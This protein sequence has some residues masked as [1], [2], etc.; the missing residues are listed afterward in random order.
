[1]EGNE[2]PASNDTSEESSFHWPEEGSRISDQE[3]QDGQER[4]LTF[5]LPSCHCLEERIKQY[6]NAKFG[7]EVREK[8]QTEVLAPDHPALQ[9]FQKALKEHLQRQIERL[10]EEIYEFDT[11]IKNKN[12]QKEEMGVAVYELQQAVCKQQKILEEYIDNVKTATAAREELEI[13]VRECKQKFKAGA[14][15]LLMAQKEEKELRNEVESINLLVQQTANWEKEVESEIKISKRMTEKTRKDQLQLMEEKRKQD[16]I[17]YRLQTEV[18]RLETELETIDMK[19]EIKERERE[20]LAQTVAEGSTTIDA[21]EAEYRCLMHS[22]N[23]VVIAIG[24]RDKVL[25]CVSQEVQKYEEEYKNILCETEQIRKLA[26]QEM[27]G[28]E[29]LTAIKQRILS[30]IMTCKNQIDE[31]VAKQKKLEGRITKYQALIEQIELDIN[32][33]EIKNRAEETSLTVLCRECDKKNQMKCDWEEKIFLLLEDEV[34]NNKA[35]QHLAAK[36]RQMKCLNRKLEI[37]LAITENKQA[38]IQSK[39]ESQIKINLDLNALLKDL[40]NQKQELE[41]EISNFQEKLK[42]YDNVVVKRQRYT[43]KLN[44]KLIELERMLAGREVSPTEGKIKTAE[45]NIEDYKERIKELQVFWMRE[46]RNILCL[47]ENRQEQIAKIDL[48]RKQILILQQK[49]LRLTD[50]IESIKK[51]DQKTSR[52]ISNLH[53]KILMKSESLTKKKGEKKFLDA[54]NELT[55]TEFM[56]KLKDAELECLRLEADIADI[57]E[58]KLI[59]SKQLLDINREVLEWEKKLRFMN[60][61]KSQIQ[62]EKSAEGEIGQMRIEVHKMEVRYGQLKKAQEKLV[63]DLEQCV[64]RRESIVAVSAARE[65]RSKFGIE[66]T[67]IN[68][69]RRLDDTR[70]KI[71]QLE[72]EMQVMR[73]KIKKVSDE[74]RLFANQ[75]KQIEEEVEEV[76]K[77]IEN[78]I[79][80]Y[81]NVKTDKMMQFELLILKQKKLNMYSD[82]ARGKKIY[83][84]HK[85]EC[86]LMREYNKNEEINNNLIMIVETLISHFP[87]NTLYLN[88]VLNTLN[89]PKVYAG[90]TN[91]WSCQDFQRESFIT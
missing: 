68:F 1:M 14:E 26:K 79:T 8:E 78:V 7:M 35:S 9:R 10:N 62:E 90:D 38:K 56:S 80:E 25:N 44:N 58:D 32:K 59:M 69:K 52:N 46:Q 40:T 91:E 63:T 45:K 34:T 86:A 54:G 42:N 29:K 11:T 30:D 57:E 74:K 47:S 12:A 5:Y 13:E 41:E 31:E 6:E 23:S 49:N 50:E 81:E 89:L 73:N 67:R 66:K 18:W 39:L 17:L 20:E 36:F 75:M 60:D 48:L 87:Q 64:F 88:R 22:W 72:N 65:K 82:L 2:S 70:N 28:N 76:K 27:T 71:K 3:T 43:D 19:L 61:T 21:L 24:N 16:M 33:F 4:P 55:Q 37:T 77:I 85:N 15:T 84:T 53:N 83:L 51:Q